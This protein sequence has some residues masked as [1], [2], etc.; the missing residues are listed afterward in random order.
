[1]EDLKKYIGMRVE[2]NSTIVDVGYYNK[3]PV[4]LIMLDKQP[5]LRKNGYSVAIG[6][7]VT[8]ENIL[9]FSSLQFFLSERSARK[10]FN[11]LM[12]QERI[13]EMER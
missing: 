5:D 8:S 6:F 11:K 2:G 9:K 13:K 4:A 3:Y 7:S 10:K 1:M 12:K